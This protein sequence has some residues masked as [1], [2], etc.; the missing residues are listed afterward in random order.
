MPEALI[1]GASGGIGSALVTELKQAQWKVYG[2]ARN[3]S[4]I[5][6]QANLALSFD[7]DYEH[8]F[9]SAT[10]R[11]AQESDGL[12]LVVYAVGGIAYEKL[13]A[14]SQEG[15]NT[16]IRSNLTG[17][18][19]CVSHC[20]PLLK[21]GGHMVFIGAYLDHIRLL[22]FGAYVAAKAGLQE[23]VTVLQKENRKHK[24]TLVRPGAT[25]TAFWKNVAI[26]LPADAKQPTRVAS[27]IIEH[28]I[29]GKSGDLDL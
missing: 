28:V 25:D 14:M 4:A 9:E 17:A 12:D 22:K 13:D 29:A 5:P 2:A 21:E 6:S 1:W 15:W 19:L 27:A 3:T 20:L 18:F 10:M 11:V 8:G 23:L 16:T 24:F 7:A 26:K